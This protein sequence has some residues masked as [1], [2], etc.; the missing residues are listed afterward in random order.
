MPNVRAPSFISG[1]KKVDIAESLKTNEREHSSGDSKDDVDKIGNIEDGDEESAEDSSDNDS[2]AISEESVEPKTFS[3][4]IRE[5][6]D[7]V[8]VGGLGS[9]SRKSG[10]SPAPTSSSFQQSFHKGGIGSSR[11]GIGSSHAASSSSREQSDL[12]SSFSTS[13][14]QRSFIRNE[15]SGPTGTSATP[16][17]HTER[18]HFHKL[19]GSFGARMLSKMGWQSGSGLGVEGTGIVTPVESKLRPKGMGIAFKGFKEKTEQSKAEARRRGEVVSEDDEKPRRTKKQE[20]RETSRED[21]WKKSKK[22]KIRVEHKTYEEIIAEAGGDVPTAGVGKIID[23]TGATVSAC[24][25]DS[26]EV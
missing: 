23:A 7:E 4:R 16:L 18:L 12:P 24:I 13:L 21:M 1:E 11:G 15:S 20:K 3:P 25:L 9:V 10:N 6:E 26:V 2:D 14:P 17:S 19:Q 5:D 8:Q 22:S